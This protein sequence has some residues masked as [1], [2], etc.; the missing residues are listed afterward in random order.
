MLFLVLVV[1]LRNQSG[2]A[3]HV[4]VTMVRLIAQS[5]EDLLSLHACQ[6][7]ALHDE[8]SRADLNDVIDLQRMQGGDL[9][10]GRKAKPGTVRRA[11]IL[12][13]KALRLVGRAWMVADLGVEVAHLRVFLNVETIL[14]VATDRKARM[15]IDGDN[16]I[17]LGALEHVQLNNCLLGGHHDAELR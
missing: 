10:F 5:A 13:V 16:S 8:Y 15:L 11:N 17:S 12:Q 3:I 7:V 6:F 9:A 2:A 14:C 4:L 1:E